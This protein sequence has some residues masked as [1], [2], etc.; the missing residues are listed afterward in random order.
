MVVNS[1]LK[2]KL[3]AESIGM[4]AIVLSLVFV[5]LQLRQS[6]TIAENE[7]GMQQL[8]NTI[9]AHGQ[10]NDHVSVWVKGLAAEKLSH[11]ETIIFENLLINLND[12]A[13]NSSLN[14]MFLG[15]NSGARGVATDFAVF[16]HQ[17]PGARN[18]WV[19]REHT[20]AEARKITL[21]E[22]QDRSLLPYL[23]WVTVALEK[24]DQETKD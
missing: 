13:F 6:E 7:I 19:T 2:W 20:L 22:K 17:N 21:A 5:G 24:L 1:Q 11:E 10:I 23:E 18:V 4:T 15:D 8:E 12:I 16:L 9:E 3:L 14:R